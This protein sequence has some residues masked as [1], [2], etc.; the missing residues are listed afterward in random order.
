MV[1]DKL[2]EY[3]LKLPKKNLLNLMLSAIDEMQ[4]YNGRSVTGCIA[5]AMDAKEKDEGKWTLPSLKE[6]KKD[7]ENCPL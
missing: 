5:L 4:S 7:T 1:S 2:Y 3:I 6:L